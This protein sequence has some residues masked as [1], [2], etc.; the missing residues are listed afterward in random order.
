MMSTIAG[1]RHY[2]V[3]LREMSSPLSLLREGSISDITY[4]IVGFRLCVLLHF[5]E[6]V[7]GLSFFVFR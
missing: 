4:V 7:H 6:S 2:L 5:W 1:F 3:R